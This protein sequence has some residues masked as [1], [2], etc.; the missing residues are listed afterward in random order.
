M[1]IG[2]AG[3]LKS[4]NERYANTHYECA[5]IWGR[6]RVGKTE[7]IKE[8]VRGKRHIYFTAVEGTEQK[9]IDLLSLAIFNGLDKKVRTVSPVYRTFSECLDYIYERAQEEKLVFVIDEYPY[10]AA[11]EKS[12][13]SVLQQYIDH[14]FQDI[15]IML[16]LCGSSMSFMENQVMGNKSPLYGRRTCQYKLMPF[17]FKTSSLFHKNFNKQEQALIYGITG[18]IPKYLLQIKDNKDLKTNIVDSFFSPDSLLFEEPSNLLKQELR[19]PA[20]YNAL[21]TAIA[22]GSSKLNEIA[23]KTHMSTSSCSVYLSSLLLLGII[24][25]E[26]PILHKPTSKNTIYRL[27]DGMFRFWYRFVYGNISEINMGQGRAIYEEIKDQ[28]ASFMGEIFEDIC[29]QYL[30]Q[31]NV[32]GRLPLRFKVCGRWWGINPLRREEQEIDL[33]AYDTQKSSALFAECKWTND[34][35]GGQVLDGLI[36]RASM[37]DYADKYYVLFSKTGFREDVVKRAGD[38]VVL[39]DFKSM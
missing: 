10:F 23:T 25:K 12:T 22:T 28:F 8:F 11:S 35:V 6:R 3:E 1:F 37:F 30:W 16:V 21:I 7:L 26:L 24:R 5:V 14:K 15:N 18:G 29:K 39:V 19:E 27:N 34:P 33:L 13:S 31:E 4:L 20:V 17:D 9:N 36:D 2:R 32:A 38:N